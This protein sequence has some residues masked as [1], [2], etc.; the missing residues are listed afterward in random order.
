MH[1][2]KTLE[3]EL[4]NT[5]LADATWSAQIVPAPS[6]AAAAASVSFAQAGQ[7]AAG[8]FQA[9]LHLGKGMSSEKASAQRDASVPFTVAPSSGVLRGRGL[10]LPKKQMLLVTFAPKQVA[11]CTAELSVL[12]A[13]GQTLTLAL[14]GQGTCV[15]ADETAARL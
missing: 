3:V 4:G 2:P 15:E 12:V 13:H 11:L 7:L 10:T 8:P 14:S 9:A 5:S 1:S 6:E